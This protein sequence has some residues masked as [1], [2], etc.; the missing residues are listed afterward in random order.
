MAGLVALPAAA[1]GPPTFRA[2]KLAENA[3]APVIDGVVTEAVWSTVQPYSTFIQQDPTEG[4]PASEKT[5]IRILVGKSHLYIGIICFDSDPSK[6]IVSQ[7]RRDASLTD[8]DSI[9]MVLDTFNDNQNAFVFGTNPL[10]IEYDGQVAREGQTSGVSLGSGGGNSSATSRGGISAFNPNWDGDWTVKAQIT[11]RGWEAE[12]A[13][14]LKT[15]R[16]QAGTNR[17]WGFNVMRNIRHKN[18]QVYL[19]PI[20]RG[21]DIYRVSLAAKMSGLDV[22]AR[23][24]IKLIPYALGSVNK[25][26]TRPATEPSAYGISLMSRRAGTSRP[27]IFAASETR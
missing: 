26:F 12:M 7:A 25:D 21:F 3:E 11:E 27:D 18:E 24:D 20:P 5:E 14:P 16:Y 17:T 6:I 22:P 23:R 2:G 4:A 15:L 1:Q 8:T 19:A 9:I 10:G 13:I